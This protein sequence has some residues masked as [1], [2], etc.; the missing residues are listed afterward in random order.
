MRKPGSKL[1]APTFRGGFI[2]LAGGGAFLLFRLPA[3]KRNG[4]TLRRALAPDLAAIPRTRVPKYASPS[5]SPRS[6]APGPFSLTY[7]TY[8]KV[9][10]GFND[11]DLATKRPD[12]A[13]EWHPTKNGD[14]TPRDVADGSEK[15]VWWKC[16]RCGHEWK[17]AIASR[18]RSRR[19]CPK[20][21]KA[22]I[23]MRNAK[24]VVRIEDGMYFPSL[25]N[26][27]LD[28]GNASNV[29]R[30]CKTGRAAYGY[31]WRYATEEEIA[32]HKAGEDS[33]GQGKE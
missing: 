31:H 12:L 26:A 11:N 32:A 19:G 25:K 10:S 23:G 6:P 24:A 29:T 5:R 30:A 14:L 21:A 16:N 28:G 17:A 4:P 15:K 8:P 18:A 3:G 1:R 2:L 9:L 27:R 33:D 13:D 7:F 22:A 20:C